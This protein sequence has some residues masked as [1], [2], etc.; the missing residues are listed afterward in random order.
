[1]RCAG[2]ARGQALLQTFC[3]QQPLPLSADHKDNSIICQGRFRHWQRPGWGR[4]P[5]EFDHVN[6][7]R[8][9]L[10]PSAGFQYPP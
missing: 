1:M 5:A 3:K 6:H 2:L 9:G 8:N 10:A 4:R 7:V